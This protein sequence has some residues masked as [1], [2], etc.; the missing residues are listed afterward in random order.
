M[1]SKKQSMKFVFDTGS[2]DLW[3]PGKDCSTCPN[4]DK[5]K[6]DKSTSFVDL[7]TAE[8]INYLK[9]FVKGTLARD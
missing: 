1:G 4:K 7:K 6:M 5:F 8:D 2:D 9:G 3:V